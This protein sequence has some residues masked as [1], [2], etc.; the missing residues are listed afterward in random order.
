MVARPRY[1]LVSDRDDV[2]MISQE[3]VTQE[4]ST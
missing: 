3:G 2:K 4:W 1:A